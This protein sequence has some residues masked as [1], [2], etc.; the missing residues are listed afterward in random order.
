MIV[1]DLG[2]AGDR[3]NGSYLDIKLTRFCINA[4]FVVGPDIERS[5]I[6]LIFFFFFNEIP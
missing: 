2:R 6:P 1:V 4:G 5:F 3:V